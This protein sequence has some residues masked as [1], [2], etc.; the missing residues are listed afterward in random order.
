MGIEVPKVGSD[1]P[2][3]KESSTSIENL[4]SPPPKRRGNKT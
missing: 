2:E 3:R 4:D 1:I